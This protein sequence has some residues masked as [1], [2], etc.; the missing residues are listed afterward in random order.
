MR[1]GFEAVV[2]KS[3]QRNQ[4]WVYG[5]GRLRGRYGTGLIFD[6]TIAD[7]EEWAEAFNRGYPQDWSDEE[8]RRFGDL[9]EKSPSCNV[10][11]HNRVMPPPSGEVDNNF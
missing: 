11:W 8:L 1:S 7:C 4:A 6:G 3:P 5:E 9:C 2:L 10:I